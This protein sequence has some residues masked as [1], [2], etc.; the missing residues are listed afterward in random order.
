MITYFE[1]FTTFDVLKDHILSLIRP[2]AKFIY[3]LHDSIDLR[4]LFPI[5]GPLRRHKIRHL[6]IH[7]LISVTVIKTLKIHVIF[8]FPY[9]N[10]RAALVISVNEILRRKFKSTQE[11]SAIVSI[12]SRMYIFFG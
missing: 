10:Q 12:W 1:H 7:P 6:S 11:P 4:Y 8:Y 2:E 5:E 3:G 9:V